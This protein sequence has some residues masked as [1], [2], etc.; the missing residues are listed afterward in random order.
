MLSEMVASD[1]LKFMSLVFVF[2]MGFAQ[3]NFILLDMVGSRQFAS[4]VRSAFEAMLGN[5]HFHSEQSHAN[6][7]VANMLLLVYVVVAGVLLINLFVAMMSSTYDSVMREAEHRWQ[8]ERARIID[9][10]EGEMT[11]AQRLSKVNKFWAE[12]NGSAYLQVMKVDEEY[13]SVSAAEARALHAAQAAGH[14]LLPPA[15]RLASAGLS[16]RSVALAAG[17]RTEQQA[18]RSRFPVVPSGRNAANVRAR[19]TS[20]QVRESSPPALK[21]SPRKTPRRTPRRRKAAEK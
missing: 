20:K 1:M 5:F 4:Q 3:A 6:A 16:P 13:Y 10:I 2:Q 15:Q 18:Q 21:Q 9:S 8:L 14:A 19:S 12:Y 7:G 17:D 11:L